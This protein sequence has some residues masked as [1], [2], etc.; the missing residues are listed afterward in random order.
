MLTYHDVMSAD[1]GPLNAAADKWQK[2]ADE[3][4]KVENAYRDSVQKITMGQTWLGDSATAAHT[5]FAATRYEYQAAQTQA[6]ATAT[7]LRNAHQQ[8][9]ELKKQLENARADAVKAGMKVSEQGNVAYDWDKLTP[10][11]RE[12]ARHD[13]DHAS[14]VRA[15]EQSWREYIASC[16]KAVNDADTDL[17]KDL[18]SAVKDGYGAKN[19]ETLGTGFN[20][21]A[22]KVAAADDKQKQDRMELNALKIRDNETLEDWLLR[23]QRDGVEKITGSKQLA[24]LFAAV[25]KGT[26]TAGAFARAVGVSFSSGRKLYKYLKADKPITAAGTFI[27]SR[28]NMRVASA[29]PGSFWSRLPPNLVTALT[30]SDEAARLGSY[31]KNNTLVVPTAAES[32]LIRVAQNG[33][34]ANAAKAAGW[35]RGTTLVGNVAATAY[36]IANLTTYNSDMIKADPAKFATDL[37]GTAF[38]ASM[39]ALTVAPSPVTVGL[40]IGTGV[41]YAGCLIWDNHEAIG[42]GFEKAGDWVGDKASDIGD[43]IASGAK[44]LGSALNPF[45]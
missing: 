3:I 24:D 35:L 28:V 10:A 17:K 23:L 31:M 8:F 20:G 42:K 29:A 33:G 19:D 37:S 41:A 16:V 12:A 25:Q 34:L 44:K 6:K 43:G 30:G 4:H 39:T 9:T 18:E 27:G 11:E 22:G 7:L 1:F 26:I 13:P 15:S 36:G 40:A 21:D 45:D 38:N 32:N 2:M 5:N 14:T